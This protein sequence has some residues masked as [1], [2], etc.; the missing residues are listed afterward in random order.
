MRKV[1]ILFLFVVF[2]LPSC[3]FTSFFLANDQSVH[4][5]IRVAVLR[6]AEVFTL[7]IQGPYTISDLKTNQILSEGSVLKESRVAFSEKGIQFLDNDLSL[8]A[9][10]VFAQREASIFVNNKSFRGEIDIFKTE[11]GK[12]TVVNILELEKY[13]KG[14]LAHEVPDRWPLETLKAQAVAARTYAFYIKENK[15]H[16]L[17]DLTNDIFSQVYGGRSGEKY[18][19]NLAVD[20]TRGLIL[21]QDDKVLPA[22]YHSTCAGHTENVQELWSQDIPSLQ[23]QVCVFCKESPHAFWKKNMRLKDIQ[24]KLNAHSY[25][26]DLIKDIQVVERNASERIKTLKI[27]TRDGKE[28]F[29]SGKD[30]R[31]IVGPNLIKSNNYTIEMKGYFVDFYGKGWG[32]GVGLCQWGARAMAQQGYRFDEI[33]NYY[34]PGARIVSWQVLQRKTQ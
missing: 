14:V 29:I 10:R 22:Y 3:S 17:Y 25:G 20:Q 8:D 30:F 21:I 9:L 2:F 16:A 7:K 26:L 23:G 19:T 18:R 33:L 11:N 12:L 13:I 32:H 1:Y 5:T 15:R 4:E 31:N 6:D 24:D 34:Y 27:V 28:V